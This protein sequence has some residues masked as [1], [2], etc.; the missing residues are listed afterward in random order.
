MQVDSLSLDLRT[1]AAVTLQRGS[2]GLEESL[3][4][5]KYC[6]PTLTALRLDGFSMDSPGGDNAASSRFFVSGPSLH[7]RACLCRAVCIC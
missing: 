3:R 7:T 4:I 5:A 2:A 6:A 1:F